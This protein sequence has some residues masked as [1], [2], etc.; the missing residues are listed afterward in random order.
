MTHDEIQQLKLSVGRQPF[1]ERLAFDSSGFTQCPFHSGDS[2]KSFHL[3]QKDGIWLGKCFSDCSKNGGKAMDAVA[4]VQKKDGVSFP[5]ALKRLGANPTQTK[6]AVGKAKPKK[7][8]AAQWEKWGRALTPADIER[9]AASRKDKT[10]SFE[11]FQ[12][13]GCRVKGDSIGFPLRRTLYDDESGQPT[14]VE[15]YTVKVRNLDEKDFTQENAVSQ[16]GFFNLDTI[17]AFED[18]YIVEGEPD[19]A[20]LEEV[21][22]RAVSVT[23]GGQQKFDAAALDIIKTASRI[24]LMGDTDEV[25]SDCMNRLQAALP[26]EKTYRIRLSKAKDACELARK[27]GDAFF[28]RV[29]ELSADSEKSWVV[30][31]V[32]A[33]H[34][35]SNEPQRWVIDNI[36]PEGCLTLLAGKQGSQ[37]S[38]FGMLAAKSI[39]SGQPFLGRRFGTLL[40][41][42]NVSEGTSIAF[43]TMKAPPVLYI[44]RENPEAMVNERR[45][46]VGI[47][48]NRNF[49][50]WLPRF[51][52]TP[53]PDD[54]RLIEFAA[55]ERGFIIF[56]SLQ[57]WYGNMSE[58]DN[59]A[60]VA[61]MNKF[62]RLARLGAGVLVLHHDAK[63]GD[64]GYRGATSIVG[65][66]DMCIKAHKQE[67]S[68]VVELSEIRFRLCATWQ[69]DY[70]I[71]YNAPPNTYEVDTVRDFTPAQAARA[72]VS[73]DEA[74]ADE[75][76][77]MLRKN[78]KLDKTAIQAMNPERFGRNR[79]ERLAAK[80]GWTYDRKEKWAQTAPT[81]EE[82]M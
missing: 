76:D 62:Q 3:H 70:Q 5:E 38:M 17:N 73:K 61:L 28:S 15:F 74:D 6:P 77:A 9:L 69:I 54:P 27:Y 66:P 75:L 1:D 21:G 32:P 46:K 67:M 36:F 82:P 64:T 68:G 42:V 23:A 65:V 2:N 45:L 24:F 30:Q 60:M 49:R 79:L 12:Q 71:H 63:Y 35:L 56:D 55:R 37:K 16:S 57:Q 72:R 40:H 47:V 14:G 48:G 51:E 29:E 7:M 10:A 50:Y 26:P 43:N 44:D 25:G 34:Q 11:T 80:R 39:A 22:F 20:V 8:T 58:I 78:P 4:F 41:S 18:V 59:T 53:E 52:A 13:L 33:I 31:T 81:V 19:V